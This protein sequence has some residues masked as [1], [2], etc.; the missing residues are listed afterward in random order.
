[1]GADD[2]NAL[3]HPLALCAQ[4]LVFGGRPPYVGVGD[5]GVAD[6]DV[7]DCLLGLDT[8]RAPS[9]APWPG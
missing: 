7:A 3:G 2:G 9:A 6:V 1:M 4:D 8:T 5:I